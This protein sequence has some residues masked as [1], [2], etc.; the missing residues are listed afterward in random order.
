MN[1]LLREEIIEDLGLEWCPV[2][3]HYV[4]RDCFN[5]CSECS[6]YIEM[7]KY[8]SSESEKGDV[9]IETS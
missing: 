7:E 6:E 3:N 5:Y 4:H 1:D 2:T 9:S 8:Y